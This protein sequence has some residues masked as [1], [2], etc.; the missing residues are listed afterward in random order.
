MEQLHG[1][2]EWVVA[3]I[4]HWHGWVSGGVLAFGLEVGDKLWDWKIGKRTFAIILG[5]GLLWSVF[6]AWRDEH[7]NTEA[8]IEGKAE[9]W[10]KYNACDKE[11]AVK[12]SLVD[13]YSGELSYQHSR[14]DGQQLLFDK[15]L[16]YLGAKGS[17]VASVTVKKART[18][19]QFVENGGRWRLWVLTASTSKTLPSVSGVLSCD[20]P[21]RLVGLAL[22]GE[23]WGIRAGDQGQTS[24]TEIRLHF[25]SPA[26]NSDVPLVAAIGVDNSTLLRDCRFRFD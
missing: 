1:F 7:R 2:P 23:Q 17:T 26:W 12:A 11:R 18:D 22:A 14:N 8:V 10:A 19:L 9:A 3:V 25:T 15:C 6:A 21:F 24:N 4:E 16:L 5:V 20:D 13:T